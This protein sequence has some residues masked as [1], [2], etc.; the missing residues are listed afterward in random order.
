MQNLIADFMNWFTATFA[1]FRQLPLSALFVVFVSVTISSISNLA[2]KRFADMRTLK[3]HQKQIKE[4]QELQKKAEE[5]QD[6]NM[7]KK[8]ERKRGYI[9]KIQREMLSE[10]CKPSLFFFIPFALFFTILRA[11]FSGPEGDLIVAV[12][13]FSVHK[14][15][16]FLVGWI[17]FPTPAGFGM[18]FWG[19]YLLSG[20]G[21]SSILQRIMGTQ[22][23]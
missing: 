21:L 15:L 3:R 19:F 22:V 14:V 1:I 13:P 17:G 8:L 9:E 6:E 11:F 18:T 7:L 2:M 10:R 12:L 5:S 4:F 23:M 20:L 16:P